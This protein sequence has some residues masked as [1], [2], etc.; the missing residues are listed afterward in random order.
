MSLK[1]LV[2]NSLQSLSSPS[3]A[4]NTSGFRPEAF[5]Q[6]VMETYGRFPIALAGGKGCQ[7][8][9]TEG[10]AYLDFVAGIA[11]C[12]LRTCSSSDGG[13]SDAANPKIA[14]CF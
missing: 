7:V 3:G 1:P 6:H 2:S 11:T 8:W 9:D 14:S 13:S 5:D 10:R 12:T 4:N